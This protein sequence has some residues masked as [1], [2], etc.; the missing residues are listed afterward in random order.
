M[1]SRIHKAIY[2]I[3]A[4][5][6]LFGVLFLLLNSSPRG[7]V[8]HAVIVAGSHTIPVTIADTDLLRERGLSGT[9]TL[10][11]GTGKFFT[12]DRPGR[13]GFW[14]KDMQYSLDIVWINAS[15]RVVG[16]VEQ[17]A[18][19]TY[20]SSFYPPSDVQYVLE[21]NGGEAKADGLVEGA[22]LRMQ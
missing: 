18:P 16:V 5:G 12:F 19:E 10:A 17:A 14:M 13:Y 11:T 3:L 7:K 2:S 22:V 6:A 20:P 15:M 9:A 4:L 1:K 8:G 21:V